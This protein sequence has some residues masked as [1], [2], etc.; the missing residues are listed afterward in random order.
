MLAYSCL[1]AVGQAT[2]QGALGGLPLDLVN[3][4]MAGHPDLVAYQNWAKDILNTGVLAIV[5]CAPLGLLII[6]ERQLVSRTCPGVRLERCL[7]RQ[8]W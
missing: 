1:S 6:G 5:I 7:P 4:H 3:A 8:L 2:I